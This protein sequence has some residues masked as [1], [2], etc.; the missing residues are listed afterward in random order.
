MERPRLDFPDH[1]P[2]SMPA[3][4]LV[5][6]PSLGVAVGQRF[7]PSRDDFSLLKQ[8]AARVGSSFRSRLVV[9]DFIRDRAGKWWFLEAGPG[10]AAGT[11]HEVV[12]KFVSE[13]VR[14]G[15]PNCLGNAVGGQL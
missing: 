2:F 12:F 6:T 8:L 1:R 11:A 10:S 3:A 15:E 9:A 13:S 14:G 7:P 4:G 5:R